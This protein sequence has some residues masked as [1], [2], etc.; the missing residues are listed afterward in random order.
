MSFTVYKSSA[1]SG[2]THALVSEYLALVIENPDRFRNI[3][4]ITFTNK[5]AYEMKSRILSYLDQLSKINFIAK[6]PVLSQLVTGLNEN[7]G[8]S[9]NEISRR[10]AIALSA[11][12]HNY[13]YFAVGTID[14]FVHRLV[15]VFARELKLPLNF[16]VELDSDRL[17]SK[18]IELLV[19]KVGRDEKLT[20]I[21]VKFIESNLDD[22][23]SW[24]IER[25]LTNFAKILLTEESYQAVKKLQHLSIDDFKK[26]SDQI[27]GYIIGFEKKVVDFS[28]QALSLIHRAD[29]NP[30]SFYQGKRGIYTYF[31][32]LV[33]GKFDK[34]L[35][36]RYTTET[37]GEDKWFSKSCTESDRQAIQ[38][39]ASGLTAIYEQLQKHIKDN[40]STYSLYK[41][42]LKNLYPI[43]VL[44][45][46]EKVIDEFRENENIVHISEFN[47]RIGQIIEREPVPFIYE[48]IGEKFR[49]FLLD[50]FQ[51][52][53]ILQWHNLIPLLHNSLSGNNFN[54]IVGDGK[55]AIYRWRSG[56]VEQ[57][58]RLPE[59]KFPDGYQGGEEAS[60]LIKSSYKEKTLDKNY[61]SKAEIV[62]FNNSFFSLKKKYLP[63]ELK[64]IYESVAQQF[65]PENT[66][67][68]VSLNFLEKGD[69]GKEAFLEHE[70]EAVKDIITNELTGFNLNDIAILTRSNDEGSNIARYLLQHGINVI[71]SEFL[72]LGSNPEVG[73]LISFF[74]F[75]HD[76]SNKIV[77][78]EILSYLVE[79]QKI[80]YHDLNEAFNNCSELNPDSPTAIELIKICSNHGFS[81]SEKFISALTLYE[82][83]DEII[84]IF[85][86]DEDGRNPFLQFFLDK[87]LEYTSKY[88]DGISG[89]LKYWSENHHKFSVVVPE[90]INAVKVL[91]IHKAKGLQFPVVIY[92]FAAQRN[93]LTKSGKWVDL[94]LPELPQLKTALIG[95]NKSIEDTEFAGLKTMEEGRSFLD[96]INILYVVM[97]RPV[98]RLYILTRNKMKEDKGWPEINQYP[99]IPDMFYEYL[100]ETDQWIDGKNDYTFG[101]RNT[102]VISKKI[103]SH[104]S[105]TEI[106]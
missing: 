50:E 69:L 2:K 95:L 13:S 91:T 92:P 55:Q 73:F 93:Q 20:M 26:I 52:T 41:L 39:T 101:E 64:K 48:R 44:N 12:L 105:P 40:L 106:P 89:F 5:A 81:V 4:A 84:R 68:L 19:N 77:V 99:D 86:L 1:G 27:S 97:T 79:K 25:E 63:D 82:L 47:K 36:T 80:G 6:T 18:A 24:L 22:E 78:A 7:L 102:E 11:I 74:A 46:I 100:K 35:P 23:K 76:H 62:E 71:S 34:L 43:A 60:R 9:E 58:A 21:L 42:L 16:D 98:N 10:A 70:L 3:L 96:L 51:D 56:E 87:I 75:L 65:N 103:I 8:I 90:G 17:I 37:F 33:L 49:H 66:G 72:M 59:I 32:N 88:T 38:E 28:N 61:R 104:S 57:F 83:S 14:S 29:I 45:E 94:D 30:S 85:H 31:S 67:G 54:M 53:S 15:K